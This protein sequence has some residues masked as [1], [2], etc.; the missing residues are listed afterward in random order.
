LQW[1]ISRPLATILLAL[2]AV[3]F[4]R[5]T[6]RQDKTDRNFLIAAIVFAVYYNLS[7]LAKTWVEQGVI[8]SIPGIWWLDLLML[9]ALGIYAMLP[10]HKPFSRQ[11]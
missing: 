7:G 2:I 11:Q 6:P 5:I 4:I 3:T 10:R 8:G 1:R 9:L